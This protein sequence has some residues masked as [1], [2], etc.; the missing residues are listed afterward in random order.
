MNQEIKELIDQVTDESLRLAIQ[1]IK[2]GACCCGKR[3]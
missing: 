3:S 1:P 2:A